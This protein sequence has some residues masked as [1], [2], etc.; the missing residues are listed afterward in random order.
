MSHQLTF[1]EIKAPTTHIYY[2]FI[3]L[4]KIHR[5]YRP[6]PYKIFVLKNWTYQEIGEDT[7]SS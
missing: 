3:Y 1:N 2:L 4:I 7:T 6:L 5:S